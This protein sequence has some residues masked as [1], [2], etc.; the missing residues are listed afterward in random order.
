MGRTKWATW[1]EYLF[2]AELSCSSTFCL[3]NWTSFVRCFKN[4]SKCTE[5]WVYIIMSIWAIINSGYLLLA[6]YILFCFDNTLLL[7]FF[8]LIG[9]HLLL[10][11]KK[12]FN[13][14]FTRYRIFAVFLSLKWMY[15]MHKRVPQKET[16]IITLQM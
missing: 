14:S 10:R 4:G 13:I 8:L 16:P 12:L 7:F 11:N 5:P 3:P 9:V 6:W 15:S 1:Q 2:C